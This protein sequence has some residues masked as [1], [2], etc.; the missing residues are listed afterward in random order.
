MAS[1]DASA[2]STIADL[3]TRSIPGEWIARWRA[4]GWT[5]QDM[6]VVDATHLVIV[7]HVD[8]SSSNVGGIPARLTKYS[9]NEDH[10]PYRAD[11]L[12]LA[13]LGHYRE[14]HRDLEGTWDR[15][16][17]RSRVPSTLEEM[18]RRHGVRAMPNGAHLVAT[19]TTYEVEDTNLIYCTTR[20]SLGASRPREWKFAS[21]VRDVSKFALQLGAEFARQ[22]NDGPHAAM[23][24][25]DWLVSAAIRSSRLAS[26]VHVYHGPVVYDDH[27]G[28]TLFTRIPGHTRGLAAHFFKRVTFQVQREYRFVLSAQGRRPVGDEFYLE[29]TPDLRGVFEKP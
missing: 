3:R 10:A 5:L 1:S 20:T 13:T 11:F 28:E 8:H 17:G 18:S 22:C 15:M 26:V 16:E 19:E 6:A 4:A 7:F 24:G 29:I 25:L 12:K 9:D 23:T 2:P 21:R 27:A 14:H